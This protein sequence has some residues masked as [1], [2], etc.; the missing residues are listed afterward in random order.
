MFFSLVQ[1]LN[2]ALSM[3]ITES[4]IIIL[5]SSVQLQNASL[6]IV[7]SELERVIFFSLVQ[8]LNAPSSIIVTE[9]GMVILSRLVHFPKASSPI[10]V[11]ELG[12][13]MLSMPQS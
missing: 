12:R 11:S 5:S 13:V 9:S 2:A 6:L 4:G 7:V 3:L 10:V 1:P 8:P